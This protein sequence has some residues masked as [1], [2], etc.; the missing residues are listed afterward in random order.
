MAIQLWNP[1]T[2]P[3]N[4]S[5]LFLNAKRDSA[6]DD[7]EITEIQ[8]FLSRKTIAFYHVTRVAVVDKLISRGIGVRDFD[9]Y[10]DEVTNPLRESGLS[11]ERVTAV[12]KALL[13]SF[14]C[15][16]NSKKHI[17]SYFAANPF[18]GEGFYDYCKILGGETALGACNFNQDV[19]LLRGLGTPVICEAIISYDALCEKDRRLFI[20]GMFLIAQDQTKRLTTDALC[21]VSSP[22]AINRIMNISELLEDPK[23][24]LEQRAARIRAFFETS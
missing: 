2:Y 24:T 9:E 3:K 19:R 20:N 21:S 4:L 6:I 23:I 10:L 15:R 5:S 16:E 17:V 22:C 11:R 13:R 1:E 18:N 8:K 14:M 12:R 7:K